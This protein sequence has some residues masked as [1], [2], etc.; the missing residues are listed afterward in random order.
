MALVDHS[1][2]PLGMGIRTVCNTDSAEQKHYF[3]YKTGKSIFIM[4]NVF[5]T[6][7]SWFDVQVPK[8]AST[9]SNFSKC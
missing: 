7:S 2:D 6:S 3:K 5:D 9:W 1:L 4:K 8:T